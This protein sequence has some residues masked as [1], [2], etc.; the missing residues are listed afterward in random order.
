LTGKRVADAVAA[1][2]DMCLQGIYDSDPARRRTMAAKGYEALD[3]WVDE[4]AAGC[5]VVV[6]SSDSAP[7]STVPAIYGPS[8]Q[9]DSAPLFT[10]LS[11]RGSVLHRPALRIPGADALAFARLVRALAGDIKIERLFSTVV[12]RAGHA[13]SSVTGCID[14]LEPVFDDVQQR[15]ELERAI[16]PFVAACHVRR[17]RAPYTHSHL[18]MMKLDLAEAVDRESVLALLTCAPRIMVGA[19]RDGLANTAQL[20]EFF[21]NLSRSRSD[22]PEVFVWEESVVVCERSLYLMLD[23]SPEATPIPEIIDA[24]RLSQTEGID[25][26]ES[27]SRTD[28]ALGIGSCCLER[29]G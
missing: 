3:S 4:R 27:I 28:E 15:E 25:W 2:P 24:I 1:Q 7:I 20:Q 29:R 9:C 16:G 23:I 8:V 18:H 13:T 12:V 5:D 6:N 17:V 11:D 22:R 26:T 14:A 10:L 21:R 19:G